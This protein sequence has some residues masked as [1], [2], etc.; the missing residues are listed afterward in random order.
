M[1]IEIRVDDLSGPRTQ[2]LIAAHLRGMHDS[3]PPESVHALDLA[4][5]RHPSITFWSAWVDGELAGIGALKAIDAP[6]AGA[7]RG[8]IKSMRVDD[9]YRGAGIGRALLRHIISAA[10]E[11]G[12]ASLWLET[13]TPA[14]FIPA[15]ALYAAEGFVE[16]GPFGDYVDDPFS[17]FM[18]LDIG[19]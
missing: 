3:S 11:R 13:G 19:G 6:G 12:Y 10:R 16:C 2:A 8:E 5:L 15:R 4:G 14:D 7:Q 17:V 18:T 1:A 9:R